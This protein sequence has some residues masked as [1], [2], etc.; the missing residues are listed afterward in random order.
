MLGALKCAPTE[1]R[2]LALHLHLMV[3]LVPG[4]CLEA[5]ATP[6]ELAMINYTEVT[7]VRIY[8][9]SM[10]EGKSEWKKTIVLTNL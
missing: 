8:M 5:I 6:G 10:T 1:V 2:P 3:L 9:V 4:V 7:K